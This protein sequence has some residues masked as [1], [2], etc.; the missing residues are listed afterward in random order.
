M[1]NGSQEPPPPERTGHWLSDQLAA[2]TAPKEI[3]VKFSSESDSYEMGNI[4]AISKSLPEPKRTKISDE[5]IDAEI[6]RFEE[7][8]AALI[9]DYDVLIEHAKTAKEKSSLMFE[10]VVLMD[11]S[12]KNGVIEGIRKNLSAE[13]ALEENLKAVLARASTDTSNDLAMASRTYFKNIT[14]NL[15]LE[16]GG[17][18]LRREL[19]SR[20]IIH[21]PLDSII[22]IESLPVK[23]VS[24]FFDP[25]TGKPKFRALINSEGSKTDHPSIVLGGAGVPVGRIDAETLY[26]MVTGQFV[27]L[28]GPGQ[29]LIINPKSG[30]VEHYTQLK[31]EQN[32]LRQTLKDVSIQ[33]GLHK[34]VSRDGIELEVC[35]NISGPKDARRATEVNANGV[36]LYRTEM[37]V[38]KARDEDIPD[39]Q[40]WYER[41][42]DIAENL[43]PNRKFIIRTVDFEGDKEDGRFDLKRQGLI[44]R[45]QMKGALRLA[46]EIGYDR[47]DIMIP[48]IESAEHLETYQSV[49]NEE[50]ANMGVEP[51]HLGAMYEIPTF[52]DELHLSGAKFFSTGSNDLLS[53]LLDI[54][55]FES[56]LEHRL[57][58]TLPAVLKAL[59]APFVDENGQTMDDIRPAGLCGHLASEPKY[60]ALLVGA[61][62]RSFSVGVCDVPVIKEIMRRMDVEVAT[63]LFNQLK[64]LTHRSE[65]EALLAHFNAQILGLNADGT[66]KHT[67]PRLSS[68]YV[69]DE[70]PSPAA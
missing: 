30:T 27:I 53:S 6:Q 10:K 44:V 14:Y 60:L 5:D 1:T 17:P 62:Y 9:E 56:E 7:A 70:Q 61:G 12:F 51:I 4:Y 47:F 67:R 24:K 3:R 52:R 48:V 2:A 42:H 34:P 29:E 49:M 26:S 15:R 59:E 25:E 63:D 28:D 16:L 45:E 65:R 38:L 37:S 33:E 35:A 50:A 32:F 41:F 36:G 18:K 66:L 39:A 8:I 20:S 31:A 46:Q 43:G 54:D 58:P 22:V 55:R 69:A 19:E 64:V 57:D 21:A 23:D 11:R 68:D 40:G 13:I